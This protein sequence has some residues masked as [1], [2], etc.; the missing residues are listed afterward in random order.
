M[1]TPRLSEKLEKLCQKTQEVIRN[2]YKFDTIN[3]DSQS[4][5]K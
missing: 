4:N 2:Y 1:V 3:F 5:N